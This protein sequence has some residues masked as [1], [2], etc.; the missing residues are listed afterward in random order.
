MAQNKKPPAFQEYA[1]N[2]M[3]L[4]P[5]RMLNLAERGLL[6]TMR[7]ECWVNQALP[8]K[9]EVLGK[10]LGFD[11]DEVQSALPAIMPFFAIKDGQIVSPDLEDY[12]EKLQ[13]IREKQ[14]KGGKRG[15]DKTNGKRKQNPDSPFLTTSATPASNPQVTCGSTRESLVQSSSVQSSKTQSS[16]ARDVSAQDAWVTAYEK[17]SNGR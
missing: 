12:R 15:A 10:F 14:A 11:A 3:A 13:E 1:A 17:A 2:M 5:Y 6:Y 4:A 16:G 9:P 7:L 8:Q